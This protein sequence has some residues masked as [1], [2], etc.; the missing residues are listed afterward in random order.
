MLKTSR[1]FVTVFLPTYNGER[2]VK[3]AID[4]VF[5]QDLPLN[6][7]LEVLVIDSGSTDNTLDVLRG[8]GDRITLLQIPNKE[9]GHGR[10]R[11]KAAQLSRGEFML[12]LSQDAIPAH[13]RWLISMIEP[14]YISPLVGCVFGAQIPR[15]DAPPTIKREVATAFGALGARDSIVIHRA[16]SLV[17]HKDTNGLSTFFS[18]V[19]SAVR[20]NLLVSE[21]PFRD[22]AYAEDQA[23]AEDMQKAGYLKAYAPQGE[24]WH[25]NEYTAHEYFK[26]KMDEYIGLQESVQQVYPASLKN[27]L[28]GWVRPTMADYK[29]IRQDQSYSFAQK[30][31]GLAQAPLYNMALG[32]GKYYAAKYVQD[33][34]KRKKYSLEGSTKKSD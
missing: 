33:E 5:K 19:N 2:F 4:M 7:K 1:K 16:Q 34:V 10:T 26:R 25:S 22:V 6:C 8:Y 14:F 15:S 29:F 21:V 11:L 31:K 23:L 18:D 3:E 9:F 20:R 12:Y 30:I 28:L 17:D 24:V 32:R 27:L 13:S